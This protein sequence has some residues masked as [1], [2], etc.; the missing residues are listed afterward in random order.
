MNPK[1]FRTDSRQLTH[2][3]RS[4]YYFSHTKSL[5]SYWAV[6]HFYI[7]EEEFIE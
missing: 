1:Q 5:K 7:E 2:F 3:T 6:Y 4:N